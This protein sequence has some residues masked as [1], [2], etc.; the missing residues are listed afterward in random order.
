MYIMNTISCVKLVEDRRMIKKHI[1]ELFMYVDTVYSILCT[2]LSARTNSKYMVVF[3][4][5]SIKKT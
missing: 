2:V 5:V 4:L 1:N 3:F